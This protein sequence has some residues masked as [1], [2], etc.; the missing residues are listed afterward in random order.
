LGAVSVA[1]LDQGELRQVGRRRRRPLPLLMQPGAGDRRELFAKHAHRMRRHPLDG[2]AI[3]Q[4]NVHIGHVQVDRHGVAGVDADVDVGV[5]AL[6]GLQPRISHIEA[7]EAQVVSETLF[8]SG[9][10]TH[11]AH[12]RIEPLGSAWHTALSS[13]A[14]A[15]VSST[16]R[17]WR[18]NSADAD[19]L[20]P[21]PGS[22]D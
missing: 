19:L 15:L 11:L 20:P 1:G 3:A 7:N 16:A 14:P 5:F 21:A 10:L 18:R 2:P 13:S 8:A 4:G 6:E 12:R 22:G 17:V 9:A